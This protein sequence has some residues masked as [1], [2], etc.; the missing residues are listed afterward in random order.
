MDPVYLVGIAALVS[1][2]AAPLL[3]CIVCRRRQLADKLGLIH[4]VLPRSYSAVGQGNDSR[5]GARW[6]LVTG[7]RNCA[8]LANQR[9]SF[10]LLQRSPIGPSTTMSILLFDTL[11]FSQ[12]VLLCR[13]QL[14][15][16]SH[17]LRLFAPSCS[18]VPHHLADGYDD[19]ISPRGY[20]CLVFTSESSRWRDSPPYVNI[21]LHMSPPASSV[22]CARARART[23]RQA[24]SFCWVATLRNGESISHFGGNGRRLLRQ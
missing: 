21:R 20:D 17:R 24:S 1:L 23:Q 16:H 2:V 10:P 3:Q 12:T 13:Q 6:A 19:I 14:S 4:Q 9:F 7:V 5:G 8:R 15:L 18:R 22:A 11:L